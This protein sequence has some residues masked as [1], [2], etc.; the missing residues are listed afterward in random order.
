MF[1]TGITALAPARETFKSG[2]P[3]NQGVSGHDTQCEVMLHLKSS[4]G[5][6]EQQIVLLCLFL[7]T[8]G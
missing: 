5:G 6:K 3:Y 1:V 2:S 4:K 8:L 7:Q